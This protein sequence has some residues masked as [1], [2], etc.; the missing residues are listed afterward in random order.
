MDCIDRETE[1][2][3]AFQV[4]GENASGQIILSTVGSSGI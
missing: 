4:A 1:W 2:L 3:I